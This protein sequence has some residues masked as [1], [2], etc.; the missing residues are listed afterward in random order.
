MPAKKPKPDEKPQRERFI[1]AAREAEAEES[2]GV[3][4]QIIDRIA[5]IEKQTDFSKRAN[6]KDDC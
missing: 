3:L 2:E 5:N 6:K 4:E 1:E